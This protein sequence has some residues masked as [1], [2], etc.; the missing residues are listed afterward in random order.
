MHRNAARRADPVLARYA[1]APGHTGDRGSA[2][3]RRRASGAPHRLVPV[4]TVDQLSLDLIEL[5]AEN[6]SDFGLRPIPR[7]AVEHGEVFTRRWVVDLILDLVGYTS[8]RDLADLVAVEPACGSGAFL[9]PMVERLSASCSATGRELDEARGAIRAFDLLPANVKVSRRLVS[10]L[11]TSYRWPPDT[12]R[13]VT[14][15]WI[16][17]GD[18]LL[19][20]RELGDVDFVVGNPPYIRLEDVPDDRTALYRRACPTMTGRSDIYIGFLELGLRSLVEGGV[21]GFICADRWMRNQ[22]GRQLRKLIADGFSVDFTMPMHGVDAFEEQVAAYPAISILR[23]GSQGPAV[24]ADT[25]RTFGRS[26]AS[27]VLAWTR[28]RRR[29]PLSTP[30]FEIAE[31]PHWFDG[32]GSWPAGSPAQLALIEDL[33]DR[34][35]PLEDDATQ[36]RV[37]IGVATGADG[38]FITTNSDLVEAD[39]LLPLSMVRDTSSGV[40]DWSGHYLVDPWAPDGRLVDLDAFP[41]LREHYEQH[42]SELG[43]R[44]VAGRR[45]LQ[46]YRTIDK[47]DHSLTARRKLLFP[48]IK[49]TIHPV[50]DD[51]GL[52]PHHN[53]Y[54]VVSNGW[55]LNV[56]GGLL[57]SRV[58]EAFVD[59]YAVKM[60]G[61]TLRFQAQY[62]RR[63]RVPPP[64]SIAAPRAKALSR[65]FEKRDAEAAT[66]VALELY[67][68]DRATWEASFGSDGLRNGS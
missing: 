60:R 49:M 54:Y 29:Q 15:E 32:G 13:A 51:G 22:Y 8:D 27:K 53:L 16:K 3:L 12:V 23:R 35:N 11:L 19:R 48:D 36:T 24:V 45:P 9:G 18:Y 17:E 38:V 62:L 68:I 55:D 34:F 14:E 1:R 33:N 47:V 28:R 44:N 4:A 67:G 30:R 21:L 64:D 31:L 52:Y 42:A 25:S 10:D 43:G 7:E 37:G 20:G 39:R 26:D 63:I 46:W 56:L 61:G 59:A 65:A 2:H 57:L 40:L 66:G 5:L 58:A 50:L 6:E 41:R